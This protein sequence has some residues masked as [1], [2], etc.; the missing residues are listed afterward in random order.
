M[1]A[2]HAPPMLRK[3][4]PD[5]RSYYDLCFEGHPPPLIEIGAIDR[6]GYPF[7]REVRLLNVC[8]GLVSFCPSA[9][10]SLTSRS[11]Y[12]RK[13]RTIEL[14]FGGAQS[15]NRNDKP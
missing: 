9:T 1:D 4:V 12:S 3:S 8:R 7:R 5:Q 6:T 13:R 2:P 14:S 10:A 11:F 15:A